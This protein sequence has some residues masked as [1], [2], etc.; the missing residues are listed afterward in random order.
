MARGGG[1]LEGLGAELAAEAEVEIAGRGA[2]RFSG[3]RASIQEVDCVNISPHCKHRVRSDLRELRP[4]SV[5]YQVTIHLKDLCHWEGMIIKPMLDLHRG[6]ELLEL[7][8]EKGDAV[9]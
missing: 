7:V 2:T 8:V 1:V 5:M 9:V 6:A 3:I 4:V